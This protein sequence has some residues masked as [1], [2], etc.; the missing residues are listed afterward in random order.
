MR[1]EYNDGFKVDYS[2][3]LRITKGN[4]VDLI[5][6]G[7]QINAKCRN[8]LEAAAHHKSCNELRQA[9]RGVTD[10]IHEAWYKK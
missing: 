7:G 5:V 2:G 4:D 1:C 3:S 8:D 10:T 6:K 9:A